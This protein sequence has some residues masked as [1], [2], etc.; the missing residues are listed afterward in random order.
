MSK[1]KHHIDRPLLIL[2]AILVVGGC[3]IFASASFGY[4]ARSGNSVSSI[5][6]SHVVLG[7][8]LGLVALT[9]KE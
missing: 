2:L 9:E 6:F 5:V 1:H 8:G 7:V 3:L 4:L